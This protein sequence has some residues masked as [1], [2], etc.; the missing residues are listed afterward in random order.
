M[1]S[2]E[3]ISKKFKQFSLTSW[4]VDNR[5]A[6][7]IFAMIITAYGLF[8]FNTLPKNSSRIL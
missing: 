5:T 7:Y 8:K 2:L 1:K 3:G 6:V 4:A